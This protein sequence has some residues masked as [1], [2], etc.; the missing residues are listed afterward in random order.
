MQA[1]TRVFAMGES[2]Q[3]A[4]RLADIFTTSPGFVVIGLGAI[5]TRNGFDLRDAEVVVVQTSRPQRLFSADAAFAKSVRAFRGPILW[6]SPDPYAPRSNGTDAVLPT[7]ATSAQIS[8]AAAALAAGLHVGASSDKRQT[9]EDA[10]F[11]ILD[12]LTERELEVLNLVAEGFSNLEIAKR[13]GV[14]RNTVKFHVSS[15]IG[16]LGATSRTEA[17][18]VGLRRGLIII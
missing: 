4:H 12:P 18:T 5:S 8:A 1:P 15:I 2:V 16:K 3:Q 17:V 9:E 14:S 7:E 11:A 10:D 6:L 13:L